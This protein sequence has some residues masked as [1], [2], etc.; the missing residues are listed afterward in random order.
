[1]IDRWSNLLASAARAVVVQPRFVGILEE[2]AGAQAE[3][4]ERIA[5]NKW[6]KFSFPFG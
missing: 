2:L 4:L 3:C 1:M 5:F 6:T